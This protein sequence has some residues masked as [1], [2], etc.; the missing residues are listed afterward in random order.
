MYVIRIRNTSRDNGIKPN[1][2]YRDEHGLPII[3]TFSRTVYYNGSSR[4]STFHD[5]LA[6]G[7]VMDPHHAYKYDSEVEGEEAIDLAFHICCFESLYG[8]WDVIPLEDA[9]AEYGGGRA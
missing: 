6:P 4:N 3:R 1:F 7:L 2:E 8:F 5:H 9:I